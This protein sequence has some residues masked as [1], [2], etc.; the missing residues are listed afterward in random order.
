M[1]V[2]G[3]QS[4]EVI[5]RH[6]AFTFMLLAVCFMQELSTKN[7]SIGVVGADREFEIIENDSLEPFF[8]LAMAEEVRAA[9]QN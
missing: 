4:L 9:L 8:T 7:V 6:L 2:C 3:S 1:C 5:F